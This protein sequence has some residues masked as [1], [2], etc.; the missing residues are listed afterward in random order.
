MYENNKKK[1]SIKCSVFLYI[2]LFAAVILLILWLCQ[3]AFLDSIYKAVKTSEIES[4]A[5]RI[6]WDVDSADLGSTIDDVGAKDICVSVVDMERMIYLYT[7]HSLKSCAIHSIDSQSVITLY[8]T[9]EENGGSCTQ[10]FMYDAARRKYIGIEGDFFDNSQLAEYE[11]ELPESIIY[12][13]ITKN[14]DGKTIFIILNSEISPV[15][16]TVST[17]NRILGAVTVITVALALVLAV[18]I[19]LRVTRPITR[20]TADAKKLGKEDYGVEFDE[21]AYREVAELSEALTHAKNELARVDTLRR[22]LIAN[23]SH[24]LRTPLTMISGYSEMM[25]DIPGENNAENAQVIID[26]AQRLTS[27]VNDVLDISKMRSEADNTDIRCFNLTDSVKA[28]LDRFTKLCER[29]GYRIEFVCDGDAYVIADETRIIRAVYNLVINALTHTGEAKEIA[30]R[31]I[32]SR[33]S[34]R[35]EVEDHGEGI[36]PDKLPLIWDRYYKVDRV[37]KRAAQGSGLGLSIVKTIID[38][39]GGK[40]GVTS[41]VGVGS[42]FFIELKRTEAGT[43][44]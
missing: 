22:E 11:G 36:E 25:R 14:K 9:A 38:Q 8:R 12:S 3:V 5:Q 43:Q 28:T 42:I 17:L 21:R 26:E 27:L 29:D 2:L 35:I 10:R 19:S 34:V 23:I 16:A 31:Q 15:N 13:S 24:D 32:M 4:A 37:H 40:Y 33:D 44:L 7:H 6:T 30:V 18:V 39:A 1:L 41:A 20:L